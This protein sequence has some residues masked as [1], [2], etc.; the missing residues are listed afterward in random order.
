[1]KYFLNKKSKIYLLLDLAVLL[2]CS[3][4]K[5]TEVLPHRLQ[6][7]YQRDHCLRIELAI[8]NFTVEISRE[9]SDYFNSKS[10]EIV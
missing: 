10:Y 9:K 5:M 1:M 3:R 4:I 2:K 6:Q 7:I 8:L